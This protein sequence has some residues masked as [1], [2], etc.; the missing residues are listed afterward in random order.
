MFKSLNFHCECKHI[1]HGHLH[2]VPFPAKATRAWLCLCVFMYMKGNGQF[3]PKGQTQTKRTRVFHRWL[4]TLCN[5]IVVFGLAMVMLS[6][7][8]NVLNDVNKEMLRFLFKFR[9]VGRPKLFLITKPTD[10]TSLKA[11]GED[12][13]FNQKNHRQTDSQRDR[14]AGCPSLTCLVSACWDH[15]LS[16]WAV[17][18]SSEVTQHTTSS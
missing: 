14:Q 13:L 5:C 6:T 11:C 16:V 17:S 8:T 18:C 4:N 10:W 7:Q 12:D 3:M 15:I 1:W 2:S 9:H